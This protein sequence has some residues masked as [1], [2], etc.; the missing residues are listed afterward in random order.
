MLAVERSYW[1]KGHTLVAGV[2]E[3]GRGCIFGP[4]VVAAV[5]FPVAAGGDHP[6]LELPKCKDSKKLT[7]KQRAKLY[8]EILAVPGVRVATAL[9]EASEIDDTNILHATLTCFARAVVSVASPDVPS[10]ALID[11]NVAPRPDA[12]G[13]PPRSIC[14][15]VCIVSGD[16][17]SL[18][19]AAASIVAKV[20]RDRMMTQLAET[21][22]AELAP[23]DIA[24]NKGYPTAKHRAAILEHGPT[25]HHRLSFKGVVRSKK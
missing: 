7:C 1:S 5:V 11:G 13:F 2:D 20:T 17:T 15:P 19:I 4:V 6:S 9:A 12:H 8:D 16:A 14:T 21:E 25:K 10:I 3:V 24:S 22:A 23:Y 18:T